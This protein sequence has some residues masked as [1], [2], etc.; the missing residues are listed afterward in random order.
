[1]P[2]QGLQNPETIVNRQWS[3]T[4]ISAECVITYL[5]VVRDTQNRMTVFEQEAGAS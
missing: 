4:I 5:D 1:M 3:I 2:F